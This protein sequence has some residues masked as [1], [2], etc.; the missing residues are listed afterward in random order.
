MHAR[1]GRT[2][3]VHAW[4]RLGLAETEATEDFLDRAFLVRMELTSV[5]PVSIYNTKSLVVTWPSA[6]PQAVGH[7]MAH[8][9]GFQAQTVKT[10]L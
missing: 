8:L 10:G 7:L 4:V 2:G 9:H 3:V 1:G 6:E 5:V